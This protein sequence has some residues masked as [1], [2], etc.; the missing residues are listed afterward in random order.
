[1]KDEKPPQLLVLTED[2]Y[3]VKQQI[4]SSA[5]LLLSEW[6]TWHR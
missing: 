6:S 5:L 4:Y 2:N 3:D 1:M